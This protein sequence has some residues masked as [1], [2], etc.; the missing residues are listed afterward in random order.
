M[1]MTEERRMLSGM[2]YASEDEQLM[3]MKRRAHRLSQEFSSLYEGTDDARR[4]EILH[5]LFASVGEGTIVLGPIRVHYGRHTTIGR[6][7]FMNFN[8]TVQDDANV[9]IGDHCS[10]GPNCT[11]VTPMHPMIARERRGIVCA[12]GVERHL[13]HARPVVIGDDCWFGANAVVCPGVTIGAGSVIGAGAVVTGD[14]PENS[15]AVGVP[16]RVARQ[17]TEADRIANLFPELR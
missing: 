4:E 3:E 15:V 16:A 12:D 1:T 11:I 14:I 6:G 5:E 2:L 7:C 8:F 10:F 13:C 17:I 9:T